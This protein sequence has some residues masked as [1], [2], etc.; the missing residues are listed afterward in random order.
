MRENPAFTTGWHDYGF[1]TSHFAIAVVSL[2]KKGT[3][4][5]QTVFVL[6]FYV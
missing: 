2:I 4:E 6:L 3:R 1:L 5:S